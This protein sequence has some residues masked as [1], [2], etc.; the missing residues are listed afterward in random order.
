MRIRK[1]AARQLVHLAA[2]I[3]PAQDGRLYIE[4]INP[5]FLF[6]LEGSG[7]EF[8]AGLRFAVE[9]GWLVMHK[10]GSHVELLDPGADLLTR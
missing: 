9:K 4:K 3:E 1:L 7:S 5:P 2:S 6:T 10:S 8:R